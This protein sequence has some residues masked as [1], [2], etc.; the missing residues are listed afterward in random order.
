M[1]F[2]ARYFGARLS[3]AGANVGYE[4][5]APWGEAQVL[6]SHPMAGCRLEPESLTDEAGGVGETAKTTSSLRSSLLKQVIKPPFE[7][8]PPCTRRKGVLLSLKKK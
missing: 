2:E 7:R 4:P 3:G 5:F 6:S 1:V 8:R